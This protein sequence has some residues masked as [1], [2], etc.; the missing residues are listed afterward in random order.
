MTGILVIDKPQGWTSHDVV[1]KVRS[2]FQ[3][4]RIGH[5]GT[6]DPLATGVLVLCIGKATRIVRYLQTDDKEYQAELKLGVRTDTQDADGRVIESRSYLPPT[7][8]EVERT[9]LALRGGNLQRPP[10]FSA[11]KVGGVPA[12]RLA[13]KGAAP[14]LRERKV[15]IHDISILDYADPL[16]RFTVTCS[17]GTYVRTLCDEIGNRIGCGAHL[18][19]L[20]RMRAGRFLIDQAWSLDRVSD[21]AASGRQNEVL[22]SLNEALADRPGIT[23]TADDAKK[24][25]HGNPI[26]ADR[27]TEE[28][29]PAAPVRLSDT[30]GRLIAIGV[31]HG[32]LI[33]PQVVLQ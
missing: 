4:K 19:S 30:D 7:R 22:T 28:T 6:L 18:T 26:Q 31:P 17:K 8:D 29:D 20:R 11:V 1:Q 24:L 9:I 32:G 27:L 13:R 5:T 23:V 33:R 2:L 15:T 16:V 25:L 3:E 14:E 10:I 12:H 21:A